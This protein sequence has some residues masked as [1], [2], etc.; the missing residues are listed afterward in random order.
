MEPGV[1]AAFQTAA[2]RWE[3]VMTAAVA[4]VSPPASFNGCLG[5][6]PTGTIEGM[7]IDIQVIP[8]DGPNGILGSAGPCQAAADGLPRAGLMR[9][10]SADVAGLMLDGRFVQVV[11]HEMA[12]VL[13][14]G[15]MWSSRSLISGSGTSDPRF[16]GSNAVTEW[17][18]LG[19]TGD[20]PVEA[21]GGS[22]TADAHWRESVFASELMTGW[23]N[24]GT[25]PISRLT[26]ASLADLGYQVDLSQADGYTLPSGLL[27]AALRGP[28]GTVDDGDMILVEPSPLP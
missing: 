13:G 4:P 27:G 19:G 15:T 12:H 1:L 28:M 9:F 26:I 14:V 6:G 17:R 3:R 22:G 24:W 11:E 5:V 10:D 25:N 7:V 2:D 21:N 18:A 16:T 8:I 20:V 23:L